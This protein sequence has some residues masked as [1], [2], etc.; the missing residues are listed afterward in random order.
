MNKN[1]LFLETLVKAKEA[2]NSINVPFML[3]CGTAL[4]FYRERNFI[5]Y[6]PD[7]DITLFI[8]NYTDRIKP[9]M[10]K[11]GFRFLHQYGTVQ[12][13]LEWSFKLKPKIFPKLDFFFMYKEKDYYWRG[14]YMANDWAKVRA[15]REIPVQ[16]RSKFRPFKIFPVK[17]LDHEFNVPDITYIEQ[18]YGKNWRLPKKD[19]YLAPNLCRAKDFNKMSFVETCKSC[20]SNLTIYNKFN[21]SLEDI[22]LYYPG[23]NIVSNTSNI[24]TK[25]LLV[26]D[27]TII[28]SVKT[29][30]RKLYDFMEETNYDILSIASKNTINKYFGTI[31]Y[32]EKN[33]IFYQSKNYGNIWNES[34]VAFR[35]DFISTC[36][37]IKSELYNP[38]LTID[39]FWKNHYS[40][41]ITDDV[42]LCEDDKIKIPSKYKLE[43]IEDDKLIDFIYFNEKGDTNVDILTKNS[44]MITEKE[45]NIKEEEIEIQF[46]EGEAWESE[47]TIGIKTF[48]R[49]LCL[50]NC[51][52]SI[53]Q[54]YPRIK[55]LIADDSYPH[56]QKINQENVGKYKV[57]IVKLP[58]DSGISKSRNAIVKKTETKYFV[59]LDDDTIFTEKTDLFKMYQFM[60]ET[61][62]DI[63]AGVSEDRG[64]FDNTYYTTYLNI[65]NNKVFHTTKPYGQIYNNACKAYRTDRTLNYFMAKT[66]SLKRNPWDDKL[67]LGEHTPF[68]IEARKKHFKI[69][70]T[71]EVIFFEKRYM[72]PQYEKFRR[73]VYQFATKFNKYSL[74]LSN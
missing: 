49:P 22:E 71:P 18:L 47:V 69:A 43:Q 5:E 36:F 67:K 14:S 57:E 61:N 38:D 65:V 45:I 23:I 9:A 63:I 66:Q 25:Y 21:K 7:I 73:R 3:A 51:V 17:F 41:A 39:Y 24:K 55:I 30:F 68:F 50:L 35:T 48:I 56:I 34:C 6:D 42:I 53:R 26:L 32:L 37:I 59:L 52:K 27:N 29:D 4:G 31:T 46:S 70:I 28:F 11:H 62:Y 72:T 40:V 1:E 15:K 10:I 54:Y 33:L 20:V 12:N 16:L 2:L 8:E 44:I 19:K 60:E 64:G 74:V 13:G 58:F